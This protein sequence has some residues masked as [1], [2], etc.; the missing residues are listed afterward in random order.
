MNKELLEI[1][2]KIR[3]DIDYEKERHLLSEEILDSFDVIS[4]LAE[5]SEAYDIEIDPEDVNEEYF[6]DI[7]GLERL[8]SK[9]KQG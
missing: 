8:I 5:L 9:S 4:I 6:D 7:Y 1:L 2:R 3:P